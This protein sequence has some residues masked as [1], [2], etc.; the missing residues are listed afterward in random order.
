MKGETLLTFL[1]VMQSVTTRQNNQRMIMSEPFASIV[2][3]VPPNKNGEALAPLLR[4]SYA[5][6]S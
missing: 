5:V 4:S 3:E 2:I 1:K 6:L